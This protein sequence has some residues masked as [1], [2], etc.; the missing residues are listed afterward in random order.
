MH[1]L[2]MLYVMYVILYVYVRYL[3]IHVQLLTDCCRVSTATTTVAGL[4]TGRLELWG[5]TR[6]LPCWCIVGAPTNLKMELTDRCVSL[7][8]HYMSV[9]VAQCE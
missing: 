5:R 2:C 4:H 6:A 9:G 1:V 3:T 7:D 8:R